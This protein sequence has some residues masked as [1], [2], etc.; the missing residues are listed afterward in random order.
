M[1]DLAPGFRAMRRGTQEERKVKRQ[2]LD[3]SDGLVAGRQLTVYGLHGSEMQLPLEDNMTVED[4]RKRVAGRVGLRLGGMLVLA[5]GGNTLD[6]SKPLLE[7]V[8]GDVI[9]YVVQQVA[10]AMCCMLSLV[11][12]VQENLVW[13]GLLKGLGASLGWCRARSSCVSASQ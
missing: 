7:Q 5:A 10:L 6:D 1:D 11:V 13:N 12:G 9:T 4:L 2:R 8:Q 3:E